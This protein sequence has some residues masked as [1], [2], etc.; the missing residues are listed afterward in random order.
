MFPTTMNQQDK[1]RLIVGHHAYTVRVRERLHSWT[2]LI[3]NLVKQ[4]LR[5]IP[6]SILEHYHISAPYKQNIEV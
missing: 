2:S 6:M 1:S 3:W 5:T 4:N